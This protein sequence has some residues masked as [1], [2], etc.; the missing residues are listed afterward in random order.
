MLY[1]TC[2]SL[3]A[4]G[5]DGDDDDVMEIG[6][7][8]A[9][10]LANGEEEGGEGVAR[11]WIEYRCGCFISF[12]VDLLLSINAAESPKFTAPPPPFT[13]PPPPASAV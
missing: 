7:A 11:I 5:R 10:A 13:A 4:G 6:S 9:Q 8:A 12:A 2:L 3:A 1:N